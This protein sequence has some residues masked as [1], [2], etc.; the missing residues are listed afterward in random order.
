MRYD[1]ITNL[2]KITALF[3][4][5][6]MTYITFKGYLLSVLVAGFVLTSR[7]KYFL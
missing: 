4:F 6:L 2:K 5:G 1:I 3:L 7:Y